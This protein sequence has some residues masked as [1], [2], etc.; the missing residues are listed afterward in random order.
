M[1]TPFT[2]AGVEKVFVHRSVVDA[3][4]AHLRDAGDYGYEAVAFWAGEITNV[5]IAVAHT[6]CVPRQISA[7][8]DSGLLVSISGEDLFHMNVRLHQNNLQLIAQIHSHPGSAYH[9]ETDDDLA[10]MTQIGG[11]SIVVP[12]FAQAE[13]ELGSVAIYRRTHEGWMNLSP[14]KVRT[15]IEIVED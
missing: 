14:T 6:A 8:S 2:L 15:L 4:H 9:S 1:K 5:G 10:V 3:V 7:R 11:L 13:F 12:D